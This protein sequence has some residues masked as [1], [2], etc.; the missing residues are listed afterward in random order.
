M[1]PSPRTLLDA[2]IKSPLLHRCTLFGPLPSSASSP[3]APL[4]SSSYAINGHTASLL[5]IT[6]P[7][8]HSVHCYRSSGANPP[9]KSTFLWTASI[10]YRDMILDVPCVTIRPHS[11]I[12][13]LSCTVHSPSQHLPYALYLSDM[14]EQPTRA[15]AWLPRC[16]VESARGA[17][18][19]AL[20]AS[21]TINLNLYKCQ[22]LS[23]PISPAQRVF[24][25]SKLEVLSGGLDSSYSATQPRAVSPASQR[26]CIHAPAPGI[27]RRPV[28]CAGR[29]RNRRRVGN[30]TTFNLSTSTPS[31][32]RALPTGAACHTQVQICC[33]AIPSG[34]S[35][36]RTKRHCDERESGPP[37]PRS[38][39]PPGA[40]CWVRS[41]SRLNQ[42]RVGVEVQAVEDTRQSA[43]RLSCQLPGY[44]Y[45]PL[46]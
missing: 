15:H 26:A 23:L 32:L 27:A 8:M 18:G 12:A 19:V 45:A 38:A 22:P 7:A 42:R 44:P 17:G 31:S 30:H 4:L 13:F 29:S 3:G 5:S 28:L 41:R 16:C 9:C 10:A 39:L 33:A 2:W 24:I 6:V 25:F 21:D 35:C 46:G 40:A 11:E 37:A 20:A 36:T 43:Y 1:L 34:Y 14:S